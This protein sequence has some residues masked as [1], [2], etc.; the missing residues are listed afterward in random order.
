MSIFEAGMLICFGLSWPV[1]IYKSIKSR[2]AAGR[3]A[4]FLCLIWLGYLSG[5]VNKLLYNFDPVF[6]LY[7]LNLLMVSVDMVLFCRNR[8]FDRKKGLV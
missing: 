1:N 7:V 5:I 3:S 6:W 2:T 8:S 4:V